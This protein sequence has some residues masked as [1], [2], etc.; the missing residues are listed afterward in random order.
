[1]KHLPNGLKANRMEY[2]K[3]PSG[4]NNPLWLINKLFLHNYVKNISALLSLSLQKK[5]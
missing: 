1:M 2:N 3:T 5:M 4:K